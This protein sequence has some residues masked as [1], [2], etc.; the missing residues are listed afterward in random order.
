VD[1]R[2][3]TGTFG[4]PLPS[5]DGSSYLV[6]LSFDGDGEALLP[7]RELMRDGRWLV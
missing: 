5:S 7:D 6:S 4:W 1:A 3:K 2:P